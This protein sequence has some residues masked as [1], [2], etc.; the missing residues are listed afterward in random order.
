M[1]SLLISLERKI[2]IS[3]PLKKNRKV[4]LG[5]KSDKPPKEE[6]EISLPRKKNR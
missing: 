4:S 1:L 2:E 5:R 3:L 6:K